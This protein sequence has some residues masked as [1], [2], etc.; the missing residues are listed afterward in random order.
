MIVIAKEPVAGR[1]KTR[2]VPP[3]TFEQ[4][5]RVAAAALADTLAVAATVPARTHL[6][7]LSGAAGDWLPSGWTVTPQRG[8]GLDERLGAAFAD[9]R[10][11]SLLIGMDTPQVRLQQLTQFDPNE[12]D[13][14]LG[15]APDGGYWAIGFADPTGAATLIKDVP[16]STERT[17]RAQLDRLRAAGL[18]VQL[19]DEVTDIDTIDVARDV[20]TRHPHTR[21]ADVLRELD[22]RAA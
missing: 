13:A 21:F 17:G 14:C 8:R 9:A 1:V 7:A 5:A 22:R 12:F 16:M 10:G 2:L 4:A 18:R 15:L 20:A 19:L 11:S 6:L 3:L